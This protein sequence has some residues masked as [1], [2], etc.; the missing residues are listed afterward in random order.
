MGRSCRG[1]TTAMWV[2]PATLGIGFYI[3]SIYHSQRVLKMA[4]QSS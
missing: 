3:L 2:V 1:T 4:D